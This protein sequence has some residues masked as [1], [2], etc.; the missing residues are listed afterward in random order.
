MSQS[1]FPNRSPRTARMTTRAA[2]PWIVGTLA[3][4][5]IIGLASNGDSAPT[6]PTMQV[7]PAAP[8]PA[9]AAASPSAEP[10]APTAGIGDGTHAVGR[11][12]EPGTYRTMGPRT[13]S[14]LRNCFYARLSDTSGSRDSIIE[15]HNA[16]GPATVT[17]DADDATFESLGCQPWLKIG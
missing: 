17:V 6:E 4:L 13:S 10:Q 2:G 11:A 3:A 12:I 14:F 1:P 16:K 5:L 8:A 15:K 7:P 9:T